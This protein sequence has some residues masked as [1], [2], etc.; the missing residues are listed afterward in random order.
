MHF[1]TELQAETQ[2]AHH[3]V[4][5]HDDPTFCKPERYL[6]QWLRIK[7]SPESGAIPSCPRLSRFTSVYSPTSSRLRVWWCVCVY[8]IR[9]PRQ[10]ENPSNFGQSLSFR[11]SISR[12]TE[13]RR[14]SHV[15]SRGHPSEQESQKWN[16]MKRPSFGCRLWMVVGPWLGKPLA[17]I[18]SYRF[19]H[20]SSTSSCAI[21]WNSFGGISISQVA[22]CAPVTLLSFEHPEP[23][24]SR[25]SNPSHGCWVLGCKHPW[26]LRICIE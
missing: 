5:I 14:R 8:G 1:L 6:Y 20:A 3:V 25:W 19:I 13:M 15:S 24:L 2:F 12:G 16:D 10:S 7:K 23:G 4:M 21:V 22:P 9:F 18:G 17:L 11:P 26:S